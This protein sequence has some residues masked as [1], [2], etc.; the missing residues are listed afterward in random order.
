MA[1]EAIVKYKIPKKQI[2]SVLSRIDLLE[3]VLEPTKNMAKFNAN[4]VFGSNELLNTTRAL[5]KPSWKPKPI[6]YPMVFDEDGITKVKADV[7]IKRYM[8]DSMPSVGGGGSGLPLARFNYLPY[9]NLLAGDFFWAMVHYQ[10]SHRTVY[11]AGYAVYSPKKCAASGSN[12]KA[13]AWMSKKRK[14]KSCKSN[15]TD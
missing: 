9:S 13:L 5:I 10:C 7:V 12:S 15:L 2:E 14:S 1:K 8:G 4:A 6:D 11:L 3:K